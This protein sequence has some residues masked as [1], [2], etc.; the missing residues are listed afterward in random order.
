MKLSIIF[1]V[2]NERSTVETILQKVLGFQMPGL[3][4]EIVIMEGGS[5]DGTREIVQGYEK[6][7]NVKI[8]YESRP[9]GKGA[10]VRGALKELT[11]DIVLIQDGDLEYDPKDYPALLEPLMA[12][13]ADIVFGS[14][15]INHAQQWQYRQFRGLDRLYGFA[16]NFG[17]ALLTELF[18][19][20]YGTR[21]SDGATMFKVF[22]TRLLR[23]IEIRSNGFDFDWEIQGKLAKKGHQIL[24]VPVSYKARTLREGKKI[25]FWRDGWIVLWAILK[26]RFSN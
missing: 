25:R 20:L 1:P 16:V 4:T 11:G 23:S 15:A 12:G 9:R 21:L 6:L 18:N 5:T 24:E 19:R 13:K 8:V 22:R 7:P 14:R 10:A 17:G 26:Y 2:L 3:E